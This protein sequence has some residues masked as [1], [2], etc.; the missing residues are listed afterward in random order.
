M[1]SSSIPTLDDIRAAQE[2]IRPFA[3]ET[4]LIPSAVSDDVL[5]KL[6]CFQPIG[7]FKIRGAANAIAK[8]SDEQKAK[9]VVCCST[10]NHGRAVAT[11]AARAGIRAVVCLSSLV[12]ETKVKAIQKLGAEVRRIGRSQDDAQQESDRLVAEEGLTE[13]PPFDHPAVVAGQG[14]I[15]LEIL[16]RRPEIETI[17]VPLSGGGLIAG[18]ALAAK[19]VKPSIRIVGIS[20]DRGAAMAESLNAGRPVAVE[21]F[22]SLA[23]SLGGGIGPDNRVTFEVCRDHLDEVILVS[24]AAIY[25]GMRSMFFDERIVAE[26]A[27]CVGH[28]ALISGQLRISGP[29]AFIV[30]GRNVDT[31]QFAAI[32]SGEP[33]Q[34]GDVTVGLAESVA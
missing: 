5:L 10:G 13:I 20:M 26:G 7:A 33:V 3:I 28:A 27:S 15:A 30:T 12:P 1:P 25:R 16:E 18:I 14:T 17:V 34:L 31:A 22:A 6:E 9:G 19:A 21:E 23:D 4:P 24:E 29:T 8:L 2:R 32:V 11:V